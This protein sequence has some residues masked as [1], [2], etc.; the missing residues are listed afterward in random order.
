M[1]LDQNIEKINLSLNFST[2]YD[3]DIR[4][5]NNIMLTRVQA[6]KDI[7]MS[8]LQF[9]ALHLFSSAARYYRTTGK[10]ADIM[11]SIHG[12]YYIWAVWE[13]Y[14]SLTLKSHPSKHQPPAITKPPNGSTAIYIV[15]NL[16]LAILYI[17]SSCL[18]MLMMMMRRRW[19]SRIYF[20]PATVVLYSIVTFT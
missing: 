2:G 3:Y 8:W 9:R 6:K 5:L 4:G 15:N 19:H 16:Y 17:L 10:N 14:E 12:P 20:F 18:H 7:A 1:A 13:C 11:A